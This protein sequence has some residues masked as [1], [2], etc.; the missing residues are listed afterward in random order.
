MMKSAPAPSRL[1]AAAAKN[2]PAINLT[3]QVRDKVVAAREIEEHLRQVRA[4]IIER[5]SHEG[6]GFLKAE[7]AAQNVDA[8]LDRIEAVGKVDLDK[9]TL[10]LPEGKVTVSITIVTNP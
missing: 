5:L 6:R 9:N 3:I 10:D 4:Q 7:I 8:F 1:S 2:R